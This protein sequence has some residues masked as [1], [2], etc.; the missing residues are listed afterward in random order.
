MGANDLETAGD[1]AN[2]ALSG[3]DADTAAHACY[4]DELA[5]LTPNLDR[6]PRSWPLSRPHRGPACS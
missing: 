3:S 6:I 2:C 5:A 4:Q 1:P